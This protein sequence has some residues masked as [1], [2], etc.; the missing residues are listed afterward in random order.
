VL[1]GLG[2]CLPQADAALSLHIAKATRP[3]RPMDH[4]KALVFYPGLFF[5]FLFGHDTFA[6]GESIDFES[7]Q[8]IIFPVRLTLSPSFNYSIVI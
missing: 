6:A 2:V 5:F 7:E 8:I 4:S 3:S 1:G